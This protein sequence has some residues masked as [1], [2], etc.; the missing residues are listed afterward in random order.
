MKEFGLGMVDVE[1]SFTM[2]GDMSDAK[3]TQL[4]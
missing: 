3:A 4:G 2:P 1:T